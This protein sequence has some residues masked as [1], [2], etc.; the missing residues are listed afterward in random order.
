MG[1]GSFEHLLYFALLIKD[2]AAHF[3]KGE[4]TCTSP[5]LEGTVADM[6][7]LQNDLFIY[8]IFKGFQRTSRLFYP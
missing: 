6:Q 3:V 1:T 4:F 8:Q 7:G 5:V 2:L